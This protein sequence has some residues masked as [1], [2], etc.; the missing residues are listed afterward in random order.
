[1]ANRL[2]SCFY[3]FAIIFEMI[4]IGLCFIAT[5]LELYYSN[6][7]NNFYS[8]SRYQYFIWLVNTRLVPDSFINDIYLED[9][10][11]CKKG[12]TPV[13]FYSL[14]YIKHTQ[15]R[16]ITNSTYLYDFVKG[17]PDLLNTTFF[18]YKFYDFDVKT[19]GSED[20]SLMF[21][22]DF[23][24]WRGSYFCTRRV[25][26]D[27][28]Y[29]AFQLLPKGDVCTSFN[30]P[31]ADCGTYLDTYR[32]CILLDS[33]TNK[34]GTAVG[35]NN[36]S[37]CPVHWV[38]A[39]DTIASRFT[40][41]RRND[42]NYPQFTDKYLIFDFDK[43]RF[44]KFMEVK[45]PSVTMPQDD[46]Y[47]TYKPK[48]GN[49]IFDLFNRDLDNY[50]FINFYNDNY[51]KGPVRYIN[52]TTNEP[53]VSNAPEFLKIDNEISF[54]RPTESDNT[55]Q[56]M[57]YLTSYVFP[58]ITIK[59]FTNILMKTGRFDI[60]G[61]L[62]DIRLIIFEETSYT[63]MIWLCVKLF[64]VIWCNIKTR[65]MILIDK[66]RGRLTKDDRHS[67][68][69]TFLT[70]KA[71]ETICLSLIAVALIYQDIT[72]TDVIGL[73]T[74]LIAEDCF[75]KNITLNLAYYVDFIT[76]LQEYNVI[77]AR[78][79]AASAVIGLVGIVIFLLNILIKVKDKVD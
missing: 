28:D 54:I 9:S 68:I 4:L 40:F 79:I 46:E 63:I 24:A 55:N 52:H 31:V 26:F 47:Y 16:D 60:F 32:L 18:G 35:L 49:G 29:Y 15:L 72:F 17:P 62:K 5:L 37:H 77:L 59:C 61:F 66:L 19:F 56:L 48:G 64:I 2:Q 33:L 21:K 58:V 11:E 23:N 36:G 10:N 6:E 78:L 75:D 69:V 43:I 73:T 12:Y 13:T 20:I 65:F 22:Y 7:M 27:R 38:D 44:E 30:E 3:K 51:Y 39:N 25:Y 50:T 53:Q 34:D 8:T 42:N 41:I 14:K 45:S 57:V 67:E 70:F 1:M 71:L 76:K 74:S